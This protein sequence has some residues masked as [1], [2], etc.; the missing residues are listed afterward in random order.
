MGPYYHVCYM[1]EFTNK[2]N[3]K[4]FNDNEVSKLSN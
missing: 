4:I 2:Y 3:S 1:Q